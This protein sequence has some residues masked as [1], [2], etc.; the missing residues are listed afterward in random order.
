M[1]KDKI[2]YKLKSLEKN[3]IRI[4]IKEITDAKDYDR[5]NCPTPTQMQIISYIINSPNDVYQKDLEK[6]LNLRRATVSGVLQT[7]EKNG[8]INRVVSNNDARSRKII[9]NDKA[10]IIYQENKERLN[11]IENIIKKGISNNDLNIFIKVIDKMKDN[12]NDYQDKE[13]KFNDKIA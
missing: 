9:L 10:Q 5:I 11:N 8:L 4:I 7:M 6:I 3:I 1:E 13:V 12:L 2:I